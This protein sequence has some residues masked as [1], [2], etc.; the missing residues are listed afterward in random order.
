MKFN[1]NRPSISG[2]YCMAAIFLL[3][4]IVVMYSILK[5]LFITQGNVPM[6]ITAFWAI[7][8]IGIVL[9]ITAI[10]ISILLFVDI[11]E[12]KHE[13]RSTKIAA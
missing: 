13:T 5:M 6:S 7:V 11:G 2:M 3:A 10:I 4:G 1:G 8:I 9:G 12:R